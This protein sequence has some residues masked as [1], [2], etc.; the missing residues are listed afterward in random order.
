MYVFTLLS[1]FAL[2]VLEPSVDGSFAPHTVTQLPRNKPSW[3]I[4]SPHKLIT[5][6]RRVA[7][8][9]KWPWSSGEDLFFLVVK[10]FTNSGVKFKR[11]I[12]MAAFVRAG[13][14]AAQRKGGMAETAETT[15]EGEGEEDENSTGRRKRR[16]EQGEEVHAAVF[17][18]PALPSSIHPLCQEFFHSGASLCKFLFGALPAAL[19]LKE[20]P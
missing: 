13:E 12:Y 4:A 16:A 5:C 10:D 15:C 17:N 3:R 7:T 6:I 11:V 19:F 9:Q 14:R 1:Y 18:S 2:P 8:E 20:M